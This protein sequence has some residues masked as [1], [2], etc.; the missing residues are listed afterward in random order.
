[1]FLLSHGRTRRLKRRVGVPVETYGKCIVTALG[2]NQAE[3]HCE[4]FG[5]GYECLVLLGRGQA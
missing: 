5:D 3:G 2:P 1:M 4:L